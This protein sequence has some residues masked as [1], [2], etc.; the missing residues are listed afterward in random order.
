[1][2]YPYHIRLLMHFTGKNPLNL[3]FFLCQSLGKMADSVQAKVD[4]L[5]KN[6]F[7]FS[8]IKMLVVEELRHLNK[9]WD[10]FLI[11]A[12]I[13]KDSKGDISLSAKERTLESSEARKEYVTRKRKGK[14][15]EDSSFNQPTSQK[16]NRLRLIDKTEEIQDLSKLHTK[17]S[18]KRFPMNIVQLELVEGENKGIDERQVELGEE[19]ANVQELKQQMKQAQHVIA[20]FYQENRELRR[21]LEERIIETPGSQSRVG[22]LPSTSPTTRENNVNWLKKELRD[23]QYV[24]IEFREE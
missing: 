24:I 12:N 11:S 3:P 2:V 13:P 10:Y 8:L 23:A 18:A 22:K 7:H 6:L 14:E 16:K 1:M 21:Q 5:G 9:D 19:N 20:Q 4:Q 17:S 15:I